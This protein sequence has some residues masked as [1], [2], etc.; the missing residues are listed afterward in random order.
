MEVPVTL[1]IPVSAMTVV[2]VDGKYVAELELRFAATDDRGN[3]SDIPAVPLK[4]SSSQAP[5]EGKYVRYETKL[6]L[7][8]KARRIVA[9][10]Y[11]RAS[12][13]IA[14]AEADLSVK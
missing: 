12:G 11:D 9:A 13:K 4:L 3:Q 8:G 10:V 6:V 2:P 1:G 7:N 14:A 5:A